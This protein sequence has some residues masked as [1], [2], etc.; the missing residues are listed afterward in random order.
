MDYVN[1]NS[2]MGTWNLDLWRP[3]KGAHH[4]PT[5]TPTQNQWKYQL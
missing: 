3:F 2:S 4:P 1:H 5:Q